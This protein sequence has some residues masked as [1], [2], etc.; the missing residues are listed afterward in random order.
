M[1]Y[2]IKNKNKRKMKYRKENKKGLLL[3]WLNNFI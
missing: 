2:K 1:G 3:N